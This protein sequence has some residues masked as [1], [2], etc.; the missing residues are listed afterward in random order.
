M[1]IPAVVTDGIS[2]I[3]SMA[4]FTDEMKL[5]LFPLARN[6]I[7]MRVENIGDIF[8]TGHVT[9]QLVNIDLLASSIF[10]LANGYPIAHD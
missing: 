9:Y 7:M 3:L 4:G 8:N 1:S 10:E 6:T 2:K 5:E